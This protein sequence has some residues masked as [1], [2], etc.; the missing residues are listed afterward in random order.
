V[1][2]I[3]DPQGLELLRNDDLHGLLKAVNDAALGEI[4]GAHLDADPIPGENSDVVHTHLSRYVGQD[5][6][7]V[8]DLYSKLGAGQILKNDAIEFDAAFLLVIWGFL[9]DWSSGHAV[10]C[11][12]IVADEAS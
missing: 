5:L 9:L 7:A 4:V 1:I 3:V 11:F 2:R 12:L 10:S 6:Y 8:F